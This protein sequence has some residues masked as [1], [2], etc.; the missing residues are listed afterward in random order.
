[1]ASFITKKVGMKVAGPAL[2]NALGLQSVEDPYF[3]HVPV[4]DKDGKP[5]VDREGKPK[6]KKRRKGLPAGISDNDGQVLTAVKRSAYRLDLSLFTCCGIRFGWSSVIGIIPFI[7]DSAEC[8][9]AWRVVRKAEKIDGGLPANLKLQMVINILIDFAIGLVP[10]V[11]DIADSIYKCN[12]K[13]AAILEKYLRKQG[14]KNLEAHGQ[15][16]PNIDGPVNF[17]LEEREH[18]ED[19]PRY[20]EFQAT[21]GVT[22]AAGTSDPRQSTAGET[23]ALRSGWFGGRSKQ[24]DLERNPRGSSTTQSAVVHGQK[25]T[26]NQ[27]SNITSQGG[28]LI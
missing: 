21:T 2:Q 4:K 28:S 1:M 25:V 3:E 8:L 19:P 26:N 16:T 11:G 18:R 23:R 17:D 6:T 13:N 9:L 14:A 5:I 20:E 7:G 24:S 15:P 22:P 10:F 27:S 12:T